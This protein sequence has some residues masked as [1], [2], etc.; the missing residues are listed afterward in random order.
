MPPIAIAAPLESIYHSKWFEH[1]SGLKSTEMEKIVFTVGTWYFAT[2]LHS[3]LFVKWRNTFFYSLIERGVRR[4]FKVAATDTFSAGRSS[5]KVKCFQ[6]LC[7][8]CVLIR[9]STRGQRNRNHIDNFFN[10][11]TR[12]YARKLNTLTV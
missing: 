9:R 11:L 8:F 12:S 6:G 4:L 5:V 10:G 3:F 2:H 1:L 7:D